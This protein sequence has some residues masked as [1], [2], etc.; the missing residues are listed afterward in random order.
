MALCRCLLHAPKNT[1][2]SSYAIWVEPIGYPITS[3]ICG[4]MDCE[5][6][7]Y[8]WLTDDEYAAYKVGIDIFSYEKRFTQ[9]RVKL[10][11]K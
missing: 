5:K 1:K 11:S 7:G 2:K 8:I 4:A 6:E 9:V 10:A 3:S